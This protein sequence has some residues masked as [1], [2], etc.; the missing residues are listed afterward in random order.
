MKKL[1]KQIKSIYK[2]GVSPNLNVDDFNKFLHPNNTT[3][4]HLTCLLINDA[5]CVKSGETLGIMLSYAYIIISKY[6]I[7]TY[8]D[9]HEI[10]L[11]SQY[12]SFAA[13]SNIADLQ[14]CVKRH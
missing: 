10:P 3:L 5:M 7:R 13:N 12:I 9:S 4:N 11:L 6:A 1:Y 2:G 8:D 14:N